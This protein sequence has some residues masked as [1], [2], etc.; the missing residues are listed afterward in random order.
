MDAFISAFGV[1]LIDPGRSTNT[2]FGIQKVFH[3]CMHCMLC[4]VLHCISSSSPIERERKEASKN[5]FKKSLKE[6]VGGYV[7]YTWVERWKG[8]IQFSD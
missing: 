4:C 3:S 5:K 1:G 8:G 2:W 7:Y 6:L